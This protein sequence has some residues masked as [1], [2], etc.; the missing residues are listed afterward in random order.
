MPASPSGRGLP[1][2]LTKAE[3]NT[4]ARKVSGAGFLSRTLRRLSAV[5]ENEFYSER[6]ASKPFVMQRLDAR[7][8]IV[9]LL[10]YLIFSAF[11]SGIVALL[12][13][14]AV[15]AAYA[16]VSGLDLKDYLRRSWAY[17]PPIVFVLSL[18]AATGFFSAGAPLFYL[19]PPGAAGLSAGVY[20]TSSGLISA[21]RLALRPGISLSFAF[22][23]LLTTR[24]SDLTEAFRRL[25]L[26]DGFVAIL[27]MAYR[28]L[29]VITETAA[30]MMEAR[31][32]RTVGRLSAA[33]NRRFVGHSVGMLFL[34]SH[35]MS[36][37][38]Y[39]AMLC[40]GYTGKSAAAHPPRAG[41]PDLL[42]LFGN[43]LILI[44]MIAGEKL[45]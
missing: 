23:L 4:P 40:R 20:F 33:D 5:F 43:L 3:E 25:H 32:L 17:L 27:N 38:I 18:P 2:W 13:L 7:V 22:L 39:D 44:L 26:P 12:M 35:F 37:E 11:A 15:A 31:Q 16:A 41:A 10:S 8:K 24:W 9:V 30:G 42:F 1:L 29:F 45:F 34:R 36:E 19:L 14:A 28:Y 21:L 6:Y